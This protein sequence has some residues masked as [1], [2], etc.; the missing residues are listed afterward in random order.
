[1]PRYRTRFTLPVPLARAIALR[2]GLGAEQEWLEKT[3]EAQLHIDLDSI[4]EMLSDESQSA[5][6]QRENV[7]AY[8]RR[9]LSR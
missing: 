5:A 9:P 1:M 8:L 2:A 7:L 3:V 4:A 6:E